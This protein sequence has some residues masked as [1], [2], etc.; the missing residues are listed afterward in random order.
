MIEQG[1]IDDLPLL[2]SIIPIPTLVG[3]LSEHSNEG[4]A[5]TAGACTDY[6][7]PLELW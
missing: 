3:G 7:S 2:T 5:K 6:D 4:S 1:N